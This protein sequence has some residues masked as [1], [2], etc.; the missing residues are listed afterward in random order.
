MHSRLYLMCR[1]EAL[2]LYNDKPSKQSEWILWPLISDYNVESDI[3]PTLEDC[4]GSIQIHT[5]QCVFNIYAY[6]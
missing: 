1:M 2:S 4:A 6:V 5:V 3:V